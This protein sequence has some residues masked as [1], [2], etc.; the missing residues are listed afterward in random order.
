MTSNRNDIL[1]AL[2]LQN[3]SITAVLLKKKQSKLCAWVRRLRE[4][5]ER[6]GHYYN[7]IAEVRLQDHTMHFNYFRMLPSIFYDLLYLVGPSLTNTKISFSLA[8]ATGYAACC[9]F[10]YL[11]AG[12]SQPSLSCYS[13]HLS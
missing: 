6:Q 9:R 3:Q 4:A 10:T 1:V 7:L 12:E 8:F 5:R 13:V 2:A 11:A